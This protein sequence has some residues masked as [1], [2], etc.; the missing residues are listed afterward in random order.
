MSSTWHQYK[1]IE[2]Q[3]LELLLKMNNNNLRLPQPF[4]QI[5]NATYGVGRNFRIMEVLI[6]KSE[7]KSAEFD[8]TPCLREFLGIDNNGSVSDCFCKLS[9]DN[10]GEVNLLFEDKDSR[11]GKD[12]IKAIDQLSTTHKLLKEKGKNVDFAIIC[13]LKVDK[14]FKAVTIYGLPAKQLFPVQNLRKPLHLSGGKNLKGE[15]IPVLSSRRI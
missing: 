2:E 15:Q 5:I 14:S 1:F 3:H 10:E 6:D 9:I 11:R 4:H 13:S 8:S 7:Y 12:M